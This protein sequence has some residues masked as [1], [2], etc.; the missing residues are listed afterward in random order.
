LITLAEITFWAEKEV[1]ELMRD[2]I[3]QVK[4]SHFGD[5]FN[6]P[7]LPT[8][9]RSKVHGFMMDLRIKMGEYMHQ[10]IKSRED[11]MP[12]IDSIS[13]PKSSS[14]IDMAYAM[15]ILLDRSRDDG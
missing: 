2:S 15:A 5:S 14:G 9:D 10:D 11:L 13:N 1:T 4:A 6:D 7:P 8:P 3:N 12:I